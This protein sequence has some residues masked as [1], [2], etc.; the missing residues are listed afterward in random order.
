MTHSSGSSLVLSPQAVSYADRGQ[1]SVDGWLSRLDGTI[2]AT[3]GACQAADGVTGS[4][5]EIGVHHGRLFILLA[6]MLAPGERGFAI[7][8]FEDQD[9]NIDASGFGDKAAFLRNLKRFG[10][11]EQVVE[12]LTGNSMKLAWSAIQD[13][14]GQPARLF[15][16]DGGHTAA[17]T[18]N[19]LAIAETGLTEG[20]VIILDDYFN[21][22][23]PA[24][25]EGACRFMAGQTGRMAPVVIGDNKL[26]LARPDRAASYRASL[27]KH[28][29]R[30]YLVREESTMFGQPILI[31]RTPGTLMQRV[32]QT[33]MVRSLRNHPVGLALKPLVRRILG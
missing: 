15:S 18:E 10:V 8:L 7:D 2:I 20:G 13:R 9:A 16:V 23:F 3:L 27:L 11:D 32:R 4:V 1:R 28:I 6:L 24:V 30:R 26:V 21:P 14:V 22:E 31:L 25:S 29:P 19:D 5:G 17:I 33:E 12:I